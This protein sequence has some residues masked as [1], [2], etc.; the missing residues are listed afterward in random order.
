FKASPELSGIPV[1]MLTV[2]EHR[3]VAY[4]LGASAFLT[5][6][7]DRDALLAAVERELHDRQDT[8]LIVEDDRDTRALL[9][10][11]LTRGGLTVLEAENGRVAL[12]RLHERRPGLILLDLMMPGVDGFE[13]IERMGTS[14][15][16]ARIPVIVLT[17]KDIT[18]EDRARLRGRVVKVLSKTGLPA[19]ELL[20]EVRRA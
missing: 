7:V 17:A 9:R 14:P 8:V 1:V 6:P 16:E 18:E 15:G 12:D 10:K 4:T 13:F 11:G 3:N 2:L 5:K 19:E 20:T